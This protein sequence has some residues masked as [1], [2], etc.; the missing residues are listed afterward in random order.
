MRFAKY[1]GPK[2]SQNVMCE[3]K[4][5]LRIMILG[6][7]SNQI[8]L[9][10]ASKDL[11]Y[12][13]I[14]CDYDH[15]AAGIPLS[16]CFYQVSIIDPDAVLEVAVKERIDGIVGNTESA[17]HVVAY[18][19]QKLNLVGNS[20]EAIEKLSS[21]KRFRQLQKECGLYSPS[22]FETD[23]L[24]ELHRRL[25]SLRFPII[26]KPNK[27]SGTRG[28][29]KID[30]CENRE[31]IDQAFDECR[32][33]SRDDVVT[34]E[35]YVEMPSLRVIEGDVFIHRDVILWNGLFN[36]DRS[37]T[38]PMIPMTD[39]FPI[40]IAEEDLRLFCCEV[41][42]LLKSAG[43]VHGEYN[44]EAYF[45]KERRLFVIEINARQGG[46]HIPEMIK[47]YCGIDFTRL[48]VST[49]VGDDSYWESLKCWEPEKKVMAFHLLFPRHK[50]VFREVQFKPQVTPFVKSYELSVAEGDPVF[51]T[52]DASSCIGNVELVFPDLATEEWILSNIEEL[53]VPIVDQQS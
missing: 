35:E 23:S 10:E 12:Y 16:D 51:G 11:G 53:I 48:L 19:S 17:M 18:V 31:I 7:G 2:S 33:Y 37:K 49:A 9:I 5:M 39:V 28:T 29:I 15:H 14:L 44:V 8:P 43:I 26:I 13:V 52:V 1:S 41:G 47:H 45:T 40:Q 32:Q 22:Y 4:N 25:E 46:N 6:G 42:T 30:S 34:V 24:Q 50:G 38:A 21:K 36:T 3:M 20:Q 27:S